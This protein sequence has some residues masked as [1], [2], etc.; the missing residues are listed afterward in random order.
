MSASD[1][2]P[3]LA[4]GVTDGS[5]MTTNTMRTTRRGGLI[6]SDH[7]QQWLGSRA[8]SVVAL[9]RAQDISA[10]LQPSTRRIQDARAFPSAGTMFRPSFLCIVLRSS[11]HEIGDTEPSSCHASKQNHPCG[12]GSVAARGRRPPGGVERWK[13]AREYSAACFSNRIWS[14]PSRLAFGKMGK[15]SAPVQRS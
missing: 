3:Q 8:E 14:L 6:V 1:Y 2:H 4:I 11:T 15:G 13:W 10:R 9:P 12:D 7:A 5:C